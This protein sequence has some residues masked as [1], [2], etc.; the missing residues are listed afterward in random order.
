[1]SLEERCAELKKS[2][3]IAQL[4][5]YDMVCVE[6]KAA[7]YFC[8][9]VEDNTILAYIGEKG[10]AS[11]L[12]SYQDTR[13]EGSPLKEF[14]RKI[15]QE[16]MIITPDEKEIAVEKRENEDVHP[17]KD[18]GEAEAFVSALLR[19]QPYFSTL[20]GK[21]EWMK[22]EKLKGGSDEWAPLVLK[23]GSVIP[24]SMK[25]VDLSYDRPEGTI[26]GEEA[27]LSLKRNKAK[28]TTVLG[29]YIFVAPLLLGPK[30][31]YSQIIYDMTH[32]KPLD[33][34][35]VN[36]FEAEH[37]SFIAHFLDSCRS[38]GLPAAIHCMDE[39]SYYLYRKIAQELGIMIVLEEK[40]TEEMDKVAD[41][42]L[43]SVVSVIR[44]G[45]EA[46]HHEH[47]DET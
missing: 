16:V 11:F 33:E 2:G 35:M 1:M 19:S 44:Q 3:M 20:Q 12:R 36:S 40:C 37:K 8:Y 26:S 27:I 13:D 24:L 4:G 10:Y 25:S 46:M 45:M 41:G 21:D 29:I 7:R 17:L 38:N 6:T 30:Y 15:G 5:G 34:V 43:K 18:T 31:P 14:N 42:Y 39:R 47:H 22:R 9:F 28:D 32:K 23:D